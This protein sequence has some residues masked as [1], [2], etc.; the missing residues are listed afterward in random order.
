MLRFSEACL[1][2]PQ[3]ADR[4]LDKFIARQ[5][6]MG[7]ILPMAAYQTSLCLPYKYFM[8]SNE[9]GQNGPYHSNFFNISHS[10]ELVIWKTNV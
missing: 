5:W 7:H 2:W 3:H 6:P 9:S 1:A 10:S 4:N 8:Y